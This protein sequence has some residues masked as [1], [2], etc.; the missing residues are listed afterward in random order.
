VN[1]TI[2]NKPSISKKIEFRDQLIYQVRST[3]DD[4][5]LR[6]ES[7]PIEQGIQSNVYKL[8]NE[9]FLLGNGSYRLEI[10]THTGIVSD[11][12]V[13]SISPDGTEAIIDANSLKVSTVLGHSFLRDVLDGNTLINEC[14]IYIGEWENRN[15]VMATINAISNNNLFIKTVDSGNVNAPF[16]IPADV[17]LTVFV[18]T[19]RNEG[20]VRFEREVLNAIPMQ[21]IA[22]PD[23]SIDHDISYAK[24]TDYKTWS[25][26]L[27]Q[28][29]Q[30]QQQILD[31]Y[32][33]EDL[34]KELNIDF[35]KFENFIHFS[36]AVERLKNFE[37]KLNKIEE[38]TNQIILIGE[39][40]SADIN[41]NLN[42]FLK[43]RNAVVT[44][45]D[46][47]ERFLFFDANDYFTHN[48]E[49]DFTAIPK[50]TQSGSTWQEVFDTWQD[51]PLLWSQGA[52][53]TIYPYFY[54]FY[55]TNSPQ[56]I[57]WMSETLAAAL[58]FDKDNVHSL[59]NHV[60]QYLWDSYEN[61]SD[62]ML[63]ADMLGQHFDISWM[64]IKKLSS[65]HAG[66]EHPKLGMPNE[67]LFNYAKSFGVDLHEG[68]SISELSDFTFG[69]KRKYITLEIWR[70]ITNNIPFLLRT[71]GT[72]RGV[73]ALLSCFGIPQ[74]VLAIREYGGPSTYAN[75]EY[76]PVYEHDKY[77]FSYLSTSPVGKPNL[78]HLAI[79]HAY[80]SGEDGR[81]R[82]AD[83]FEW[84]FR[85]DDRYDYVPETLYSVMMVGF[86]TY[87]NEP[88]NANGVTSS[89]ITTGGAPSMVMSVKKSTESPEQGSLIFHWGV[90]GVN[91]LPVYSAS[92]DNVNL[93]DGFF[94]QVAFTIESN[95]PSTNQGDATFS[96]LGDATQINLRMDFAKAKFGKIV[97]YATSSIPLTDFVTNST[98]ILQYCASW[99]S[100][101]NRATL[102]AVKSGNIVGSNLPVGG[103]HFEKFN[104][105]FQDIRL[106]SGSLTQPTLEEHALSP[107]SYAYNVRTLKQADP[108]TALDPIRHLYQRYLLTNTSLSDEIIYRTTTVNGVPTVV[109]GSYISQKSIQPFPGVKLWSTPSTFTVNDGRV[110]F[111]GSKTEESIPFVG[112]DTPHFTSTPSLGATTLYSEKI[113][114]DDNNIGE[115]KRLSRTTS[116]ERSS[117]DSF[118]VDSS[119]LGIFFS[120]QIAINEDI[121]N[122]FGYFEIDNYVGDPRVLQKSSYNTLRAFSR[123][124]WQKYTELNDYQA[125]FSVIALY[126]QS[127]FD[128]IKDM[129]IPARANAIVGVVLEPNVLERYRIPSPSVAGFNTQIETSL[130]AATPLV[131]DMDATNDYLGLIDN[132]ATMVL[133]ANMTGIDSIPVDLRFKQ[134]PKRWEQSVNIGKPVSINNG[135]GK[136]NL[137]VIR[138]DE[139]VS[140]TI[141]KAPSYGRFKD[142]KTNTNSY[143]SR[144]IVGKS[145]LS[146]PSINS[147]SFETPDGKPVVEVKK[148]DGTQLVYNNGVMRTQ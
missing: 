5:L 78:T 96:R 7:N 123:N 82:K 40:E 74:S 66:E 17:P 140:R 23:F 27:G 61:P 76:F 39:S 94:N 122:Q 67:I 124:Y 125:Y 99:D 120:P 91:T 132:S 98:E 145:R 12:V 63:F 24:T 45:F 43:E 129:M 134:L 56:F 101:I 2:D 25:D 65:F 9:T 102:L 86:A 46:A 87:T 110:V 92:I 18:I 14:L 21:T 1:N 148:V 20:I 19:G 77:N 83:T 100:P 81:I 34:S 136:L 147:P 69:N 80:W 89:F 138:N 95:Q 108:N 50:R 33:S 31:N 10:L 37:F 133:T 13:A 119:R 141:G 79:P 127:V 107:S 103:I 48:E 22:G 59:R 58:Q 70:R 72:E 118:S 131:V 144:Q 135:P 142:K 47:F 54:E 68:N 115:T 3:S 85:T 52:D 36:S 139:S 62:A 26:L 53:S 29:V 84:R 8:F 111:Y 114:I 126:D 113:R 93:F 49:R 104:G 71:K 117:Y 130:R 55:G 35:T 64:Y 137:I 105:V 128:Y 16:I 11:A 6:A 143:I 30:T 90:Q 38:A 109:S 57:D 75:D 146:S 28:G 106:W 32:F 73:R 112:D 4:T 44:S 116:V 97:H 41:L 42:Q 15:M 88:T 121:Y 60:P 51:T